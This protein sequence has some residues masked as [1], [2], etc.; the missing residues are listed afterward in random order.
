[1][2]ETEGQGSPMKAKLDDEEE[3]RYLTTALHSNPLHNIL[4]LSDSKSAD[5]AAEAGE[6]KMKTMEK[7]TTWI[8]ERKPAF[9]I[10]R[11]RNRSVGHIR[12]L[13]G[14]CK[15]QVDEGR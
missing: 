6:Y 9:V 14:L 4:Q 3:L 15:L 12:F 7:I 5:I 1:M 8:R 13:F 10:G 2:E 11:P